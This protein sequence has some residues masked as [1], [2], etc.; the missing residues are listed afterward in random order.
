MKNYA[1]LGGCYPP[2]PSASVENTL[3]GL[4]ISSYHTQPH[5]IIAYRPHLSHFWANN[6]L[7]LKVPKKGNPI[8]V[9]L[10]KMLEKTTAL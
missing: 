5:P 1:Y 8:L 2:Q 9:T 3:L 6:F 10:L 7:T 4:H